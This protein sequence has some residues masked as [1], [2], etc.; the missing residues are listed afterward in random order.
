LERSEQ[1]E[2]IF[3]QALQRD[4]AQ[5]DAYLREA[6]GG[7]AALHTEIADLLAHHEPGAGFEPWA[8]AAAAQLMASPVSLLEP[9]Q[10]LGPYRIESF[11]AAGG[12]GQVYRATDTRLNREVAIKI[13]AGRFGE[14]FDREARLIASLNHPHI[15]HLY[16]VGPNYLVMEL[17]EGAP[18]RGPLPLKQAVEY[19]GQILDALDTA[20]RKG[21]THR[22]L[23]PG[24]ILVTKKGVKLLDFGLAKRSSPL[25]ESDLTLTGALTGKGEILG[26]PQYM[27]PEQ[28]QGKEA[29]ERSDLFS[30]GCVLYE[31]LTG[32]RA[33]EGPSAASVIAAI[34][35]RE[36]APLGFAPPLVRVIRTCLAKDPDHRFQ[37]AL[38]LKTA[39]TWAVEQ[40]PFPATPQNRRWWPLG[41]AATLVL[42]ALGGAW[43]VSHFSQPADERVLRLQ[44]GP[45]PGGRLTTGDL[46]ISPDG[47]TAAYVASVNGTTGLWVRP[48]DGTTARLLPGTE[49]A[50]RP[51]WSPDGRSIAFDVLG[52]RLRR[53]DPAGGLP[54]E[55]GTVFAVRGASWGEDR[56]ILYSQV[57]TA[58]GRYS[59]FRI[60]E[61]GGTPTLVTAPELSRGELAYYWPQ[62]LPEGRFLY[63]LEATKPENS[64][65]YAAPLAK[66]AERTKLITTESR[67]VYAS[68]PNGKGYLVWMRGEALV[69]QEFDAHTLRFAGKPQV[70]AEAL[71][72]TSQ[73]EMHVSASATGLLLYGTSGEVTHLAWWDRAGK[74]LTEVGEPLDR[75][76]MF[77]LSP[78][79]RQV[80]VQRRKGEVD[81]LWLLDTERGVATRFTAGGATSTQPV[82]S[83]DGRNILFTHLGSGVLLRRPANGIGEEQV[84]SQSSGR[85][86]PYDWSRDSRWVLTRD[87]SPDTKYDI[88]KIPMTSDGKMQEGATPTPYL[89]TPF[90]ESQAR[91][92]PEP[93]PRWVAYV[94]DDSGRPEVYIDAFPEPHGKIRI[95]KSGGEFPKWGTGGRELFYVSPE[96]KLMAVSL[97]L[98]SDTVEPSVPRELFQL[99]LR[100]PAGPTYEPG[101]DGQRFL[102]LSSPESAR[103][104]LTVIVNWPALLKEGAT[105]P[106]KSLE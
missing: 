103:Q 102:V 2:E 106:R 32:K 51:F 24:N 99:P 64:G 48:L 18:L 58:S 27:S 93:S 63:W 4:P 77:R 78:D 75:I 6:C 84:V 38:D 47:K 41:T 62:M 82:W 66:P 34:L 83:P 76:S 3:H 31:M 104:P 52:N 23:K 79:E 25:Q 88:W 43:A 55:I 95:S 69:G 105:A 21:I 14:R 96:N 60:S 92:S 10:F 35:E 91:F 71:G 73:I 39:L 74:P 42:G 81:D 61:S 101:R 87:S 57:A 80:A 45:P 5:R 15:C 36:P 85:G 49:D 29:D 44:I 40:S 9:G 54:V 86:V 33:F 94:S 20:H 30:F 70:I 59:L 13:C 67:A 26:T 37:N 28:L 68:G 16:D 12:M 1:V 98:G 19:A 90:N 72:G 8:A 56:Y 22:D 53:V 100:S 50:G 65:V 7:D 46:A 17:V 89:R 11:V 97:R